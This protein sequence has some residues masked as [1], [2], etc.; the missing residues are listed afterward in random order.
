[1]GWRDGC[2]PQPP[3]PAGVEPVTFDFGG[4]DALGQRLDGARQAIT[5]NL[6]ARA[7]AQARLVDWAGGHRVAYDEHRTIQE[8]ALTGADLAAQI[9]HL[10]SA[11]DAAAAAQVRTNDRAADILAE[12]GQVP[13]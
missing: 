11:W 9:A 8:A 10:R 6:D 13:R 12:G 4:A 2:A 1:M 3:V 5:A 7:A